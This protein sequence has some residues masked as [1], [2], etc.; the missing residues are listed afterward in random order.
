MDTTAVQGA[1][2]QITG[3]LTDLSSTNMLAIVVGA[4]GITVGLCVVWF[5]V[6]YI[7]RKVMKAFKSGRA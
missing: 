6:R 1:V 3:A 7:T 2:T 5:G 4:L